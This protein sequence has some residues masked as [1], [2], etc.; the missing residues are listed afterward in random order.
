VFRREVPLAQNQLSDDRTLDLNSHDSPFAPSPELFSRIFPFHFII[1][2]QL[3]IIQTGHA[4]G[5]IYPD[6]AIN[7][8][9]SENFDIKRPQNLKNIDFKTLGSYPKSLFLLRARHNGL[10]FKGQ[11]LYVD[12]TDVI[13]FLGAP[14]ISNV[15]N[16]DVF[17]LKISDF[18]IHDPVADFL[19]LLQAQNNAL[20]QTKRMA[21]QLKLR[22]AELSEALMQ[23]KELNELKSR[24]ISTTSH[25]FR[26]PLGVISSSAGLLQEYGERLD[27]TKKTKHLQRIQG[28]VKQMTRLLEDLLLLNQSEMGKLVCKPAPLKLIEFCYQ[29][30]EE[31]EVA[32]NSDRE[33][34]FQ[35]NIPSQDVLDKHTNG[36]PVCMDEKLLRQ[37]LTNL[38]SNAIKYSPNGEKVDFTIQFADNAAIFQVQ[39]RGIGISPEDRARLFQ[40]FHR[41]NNVSNIQGT[42]LG[43]SIVK[44]CVELH[45]GEITFTSEIEIGTTF[46]VKLPLNQTS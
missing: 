41:G 23:E 26:T 34:R 31:L 14:W 16:L 32:L 15:N 42:G 28:A 1:N 2:R 20:A 12:Y 27:P 46:I 18:P 24:F 37:I 43:L 9:F 4:I 3:K 45:Q 33:S 5:R 17:G 35:L 40:S 19:F 36:Q 30:I 39:D 13:L 8:D 38:L 25:E 7:N 6:I 22:K 10:Q 29:L 44:R 21:H 11:M